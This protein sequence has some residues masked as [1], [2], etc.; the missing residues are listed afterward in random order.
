MIAVPAAHRGGRWARKVAQ[1]LT[2]AYW[3]PAIG[4]D[5]WSLLRFGLT[6]ASAQRTMRTLLVESILYLA[7]WGVLSALAAGVAAA[8]AERRGKSGRRDR[9][10]PD[11]EPMKPT[12]GR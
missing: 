9:F 11:R 5:L 12:R 4:V 2:L 6:E 1:V 8:P 7:V 3:W 10:D